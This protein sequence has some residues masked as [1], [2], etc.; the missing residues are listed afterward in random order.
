M[1]INNKRILI[2]GI[3][4]YDYE[5]YIVE[6][7]ESI[8]A[9]VT[10]ISSDIHFFFKGLFHRCGLHAIA[11]RIVE[12]KLDGLIM[13]QPHDMD[14]VVLIKALNLNTHHFHL[15]MQNNPQAYTVLYLWDS[16]NRLYNKKDILSFDGHIMTFDRH[17]ATEYGFKFRPLF[18][19]TALNKCIDTTKYDISFVGYD[20]T[21]RYKVVKAIKRQCES[22]GL[23]YKF[24][25]L[26]SARWK[27]IDRHITHRIN[28]EDASLFV[29]DKLSYKEYMDILNDS[30]VI[31]D[32]SHPKQTGLTIR[33]IETFGLG[34]KLVTTNKDIKYYGFNSDQY[35]I[36]DAD[37]IHID[38]DF[39]KKPLVTAS[40][41]SRYTMKC[42][43]EDLFGE[44]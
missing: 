2:V 16:I 43:I 20:H 42:F 14:Y 17:D 34:K 6:Y 38:E 31:L 24:V 28:K 4:F 3:G 29:T 26:T 22:E 32:V 37:N 41:M 23:R 10:Y 33:T 25:L 9:K 5:R 36:L 21:L 15:I 35:Y 11:N 44:K 8:G 39:I 7:L 1:D 19:R 40:D 30:S 13:K 12:K 18:F 27:F